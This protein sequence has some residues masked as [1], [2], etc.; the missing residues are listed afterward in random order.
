VLT[1]GE[2]TLELSLAYRPF[3]EADDVPHDPWD[4]LAYV[5][6]RPWAWTEE[7]GATSASLR[8]ELAA[9]THVVRLI[10]E[11]HPPLGNARWKH[12]ARVCPASIVVE[13]EPGSDATLDL[14]YS[15]PLLSGRGRL[16]GTLATNRTATGR[17]VPDCGDAESWPL[18]CEEIEANL[19]PGE[20]PPRYVRKRL[21][22][23]VRWGDLWSGLAGVP[24]RT[25]VRQA[26]S[27]HEFRPPAAN[28]D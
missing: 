12:A 24:D 9:G 10:Q 1:G 21:D 18:L 13:L 7:R 19:V 11:Q 8:R 28:L 17:P 25:A 15:E 20:K 14:T 5:D 26:L 27:V 22:R 6:G 2:A 16:E 4:L 23:C 3:R